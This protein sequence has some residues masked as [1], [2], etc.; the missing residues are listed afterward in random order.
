[1]LNGEQIEAIYDAL[2]DSF[3]S[4][5][6]KMMVQ[7]KLDK[8]LDRI[9][10]GNS[11]TEV[12]FELIKWAERT[13]NLSRLISGARESNVNNPKLIALEQAFE[14]WEL[15]DTDLQGS[16]QYDGDKHGNSTYGK[17]AK[18]KNKIRSDN[19]NKSLS[20]KHRIVLIS[21][22][23]VIMVILIS[24]LPSSYNRFIHKAGTPSPPS[25]NC[26][27]HRDTDQLT[28]HHIIETEEI[29]VRASNMS[30]IQAIFMSDA[31]YEDKSLNE[32]RNAIDNYVLAFELF[33]YLESQH[34]DISIVRVEKNVAYVTSGSSGL[35]IDLK[36]NDKESWHSEAGSD[37]WIFQ[38]DEV[39]C[40]K[41]KKLVVNAKN[42]LF[43]PR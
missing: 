40:W 12:V 28:F 41:V 38:K 15:D 43:P 27:F 21:V 20:L 42:Q 4:A 6:L 39:G 30:L 3:T 37:H 32:S 1:M 2:I 14:Q 22:I 35:Y 23:C 5:E 25:D 26:I 18:Q 7:V 17:L 10:S 16:T 8:S 11:L 19:K 31:T 36:N 34:H 29:A 33:D 24:V 9:V 13:G